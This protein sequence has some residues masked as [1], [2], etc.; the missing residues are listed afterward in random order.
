MDK[1][2]KV[3][4]ADDSSFM[5]KVL[6]GILMKEGFENF[7]EA[8]NGKETVEKFHSEKP[9]L[10]LL[11]IIMPEMDGIAVLKKIGKEANVIV[12]SAV[13]QEAL[14]EEAKA[15]NAK[16]YVIKPFENSQ[17]VAELYKVLG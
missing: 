2:I 11:D 4:L 16:G 9:G 13:G 15:N 10:I 8:E 14:I 3:M 17:V 7:V 1:N 6:K 5:R 12:V